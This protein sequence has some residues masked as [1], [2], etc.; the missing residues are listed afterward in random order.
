[1]TSGLIPY[2]TA[3][4]FDDIIREGYDIVNNFGSRINPSK[5]AATE[6][7]GITFE[8][9][10]PRARLSQSVARG[11]VFSAVGE[12]C[13]YLSGNSS[14]K[15]MDYYIKNYSKYS[16]D[17][18]DSEECI[19][20]GAYGPRIFGS[21][22]SQFDIVFEILS[23]KPNSRQA[24]VQIF[25]SKDIF[26][27]HKDVPCTCSLQF[28]LRDDCLNLI[29][30]MRSNDIYKGLPHDIFSFTMMQEIMAVRLGVGIGWYKHI[31]GSFHLYDADRDKFDPLLREGYYSTNNF[32]APMPTEDLCASIDALLNSERE[33]R[34]TG[35]TQV[36]INKLDP[37]WKDLVLMLCVHSMS[38]REDVEG[39]EELVNEISTFYRP[40]VIQKSESLKGAK[41]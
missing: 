10:N 38:K 41:L 32:M 18:P 33:L 8:L 17:H 6:V 28:L 26:E 27:A 9:T 1:M 13:W 2:I 15:F 25:D 34:T 31:V 40:Y 36:D 7:S 19:V 14:G 35:Y 30:Y 12:L 22:R 29:V 20:S 24:V 39:I 21:E 11:K 37:Y 5:G 16:A 4:T 3:A 23:T